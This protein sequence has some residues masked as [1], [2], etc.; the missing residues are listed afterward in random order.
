MLVIGIYG[1]SSLPIPDQ[2]VV[3][4]EARAQSC[5]HWSGEDAYDAARGAEIDKAI[6]ASRCDTLLNDSDRL[7]TANRSNP[8]AL[9]R[10]NMAIS[11]FR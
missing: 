6:R 8:A 10:I 7:R 4:F 11:P 2:D 3:A 5:E 1:C 9:A